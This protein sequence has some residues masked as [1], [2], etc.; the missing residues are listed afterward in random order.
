MPHRLVR[1]SFD[2]GGS[3]LDLK[4]FNEGDS[5]G[6]NH[7]LI[8]LVLSMVEVGEENFLII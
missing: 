1:H 6:R 8:L 2:D 4:S 5:E 3:F 7:I